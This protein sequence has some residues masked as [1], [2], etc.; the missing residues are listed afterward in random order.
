MILE[1]YN[2][3]VYPTYRYYVHPLQ[4]RMGRRVELVRFDSAEDIVGV[5]MGHYA[6]VPGARDA[7]RIHRISGVNW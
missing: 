7:A 5:T 3:P 6:D 1:P 4:E 2:G